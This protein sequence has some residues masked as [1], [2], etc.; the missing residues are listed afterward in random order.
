MAIG[1]VYVDGIA[2]FNLGGVAVVC[3]R[4][5]WRG[6]LRT[7][8]QFNWLKAFPRNAAGSLWACGERIGSLKH[9]IKQSNTQTIEEIL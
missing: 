8:R 9:Y 1:P 3:A 4:R 5:R 7:V 2:R 6:V